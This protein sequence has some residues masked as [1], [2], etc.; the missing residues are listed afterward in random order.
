MNLK[1]RRRVALEFPN[2][3]SFRKALSLLDDIGGWTLPGGPNIIVEEDD[4]PLFRQKRLDFKTAPVVPIE[5]LS[6]PERDRVRR[7]A[8]WPARHSALR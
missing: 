7:T 2:D 8:G 4:V 3:E 5:D 1:K 6:Q